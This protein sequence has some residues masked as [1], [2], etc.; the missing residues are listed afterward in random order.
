MKKL[1]FI[2]LTFTILQV[3]ASDN[4]L[5][6]DSIAEQI[7][8]LQQDN[9][10]L[11][12]DITKLNKQIKSKSVS[13]STTKVNNRKNMIKKKHDE[14]NNNNA[15]IST[16]SAQLL[17]QQGDGTAN[18]FNNQLPPFIWG[19]ATAGTRR[20]PG[21]MMPGQQDQDGQ[22]W[23]QQDNQGGGTMI[24]GPDGQTS[25]LNCQNGICPVA[26]FGPGGIRRIQQP[27]FQQPALNGGGTAVYNPS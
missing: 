18:N 11:Q 5:D 24:T 13:A 15:K 12:N 2:C 4:D 9:A 16:L 20:F 3:N 7:T 6:Q 23:Q 22:S 21:G 10:G 25:S 27:G 1:L 19:K 14:I 17:A 8:K 26:R